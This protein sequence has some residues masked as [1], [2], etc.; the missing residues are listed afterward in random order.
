MDY[1][2][3]YN[4]WLKSSLVDD[5]TKESLKSITDDK[6]IKDRFYKDLEFG[7]GGLRG[8]LGVGTNRMNV[9]TVAKATQGLSDFLI[10]KYKDNISVA[11]AYDCRNMSLEFATKCCEVLTG[12]N[13]KTYIFNYIVP[14][15]MLSYAVRELKCNAGIVITAS[16]NPKEYNGYKVYNSKGVQITDYYANEVYNNIEKIKDFSKI[17]YIECKEAKKKK[18]Y[19]IVPINIISSYFEKI[20]NSLFRN[21]MV[22][23]NKEKLKVIYTPLHGTGNIPIRRI[24]CELGYN[25]VFV[26]NKQEKPDGNF[27]TVKFPNPEYKEVFNLALKKAEKVDP[28]LILGTD[29]DCDRIGVMVKNSEGKYI[30]LTGNQIGVLLTYYIMDSMKELSR[31]P[32]NPV[33]I[34]TIV[35]TNMIKVLA[36][37]YNVEV[38]EV[39]TGFKYI[40]DKIEEFK[41]KKDKDFIFGLEESYGYLFGDFVR[42]K[43]AVITSA[44]ICEMALYYK[45]KG[46]DLYEVMLDLYDKCGY[47]QEKL[48][49]IDFKGIEGKE[50]I[51]ILMDNFRNKYNSYIGENKIIKKSDYKAS[52]EKNILNGKQKSIK[53]PKSNVLAFVLDNN[54]SFI[55]RPSGTEPKIKIYLSSKANNLQSSINNIKNL[56]K[57]IKKLMKL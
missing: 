45:L 3:K 43:D 39:L 50:K 2:Y 27:P 51:E 10:N 31:M 9:Y 19:N 53:L 5:F 28:D 12:N 14:T 30:A 7:T 24:L 26:V 55:I 49:S 15:P 38:E 57:S 13:I 25:N 46:K 4:L 48:I 8:L 22:K 42:D 1:R 41:D 29:A 16:H 23:E 37:K 36:D 34:K 40:G 21:D 20:K 18:L 11:I 32:D 33:I 17:K 47:F 54:S 35:T 6:E 52:V 44:L 56:E